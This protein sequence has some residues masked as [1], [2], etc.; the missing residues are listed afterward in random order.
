[1]F[2]QARDGA[3]L[4]VFYDLYEEIV[5]GCLKL[6]S[7]EGSCPV[8]LNSLVHMSVCSFAERESV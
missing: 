6:R 7:A 2:Y 8:L 3:Q 4:I 1:M 5:L